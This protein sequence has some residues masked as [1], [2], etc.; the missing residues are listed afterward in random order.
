[1]DHDCCG[2]AGTYGMKKEKYPIAMKVG[3]PLFRKV[4]ES[5][6]TVASCDSETCRWQIE[7]ATGVRTRHPVEILA[8]AYRAADKAA[9]TATPS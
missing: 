8:E 2:I 7:S 6:A 1:M 3:E 4:R 5:G 9:G